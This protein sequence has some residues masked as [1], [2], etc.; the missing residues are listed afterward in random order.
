MVGK[1]SGLGGGN[2]FAIVDLFG[3]RDNLAA[4]LC[5]EKII[6]L[7][8][9]IRELIDH[10]G[11]GIPSPL[12]VTSE[13]CDEDRTF[14]IDQPKINYYEIRAR[15]IEFF[16]KGTIFISEAEF[17]DRAENAKEKILRDAVVSNIFN[18]AHLALP[19]PQ[20]VVNDMG[21]SLQDF[22]LPAGKKAY[23]AQ[24]SSRE[25]RNHRDGQLSGKVFIIPDMGHE[26]FISVMAEK[27]GMAWYFPN[28]MQGFSVNAQR[29]AMKKLLPHGFTLAGT[30]EPVLAMVGYS[31]YLA[32][33]KKT[34]G[35][36][37]SAVSFVSW[38]GSLGFGAGDGCLGFGD[39]G[40]ID[41]PSGPD[42]GGLV[43][44]G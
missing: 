29:E 20:Y 4:C 21:D 39:G 5:G 36:D 43:F 28:P 26:K 13:V 19:F 1:L 34:P 9:V 40:D 15:F 14:H 38:S 2:G 33:D 42:S 18:R 11:R 31:K 12:G 8:D 37:C 30:I 44:L 16:P 17:E 27:P 25:F 23:L 24:F 41:G 22:F 3:G 35:I 7:K 10:N 32:R 6:I